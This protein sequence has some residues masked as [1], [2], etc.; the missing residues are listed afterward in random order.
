M[1]QHR[2]LGSPFHVRIDRFFPCAIARHVMA[3]RIP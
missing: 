1:N 3:D 2:G